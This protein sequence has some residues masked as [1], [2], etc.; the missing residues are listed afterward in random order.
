MSDS[1]KHNI[2]MGVIRELHPRPLA[3]QG[4][5]ILYNVLMDSA[6]LCQAKSKI[7]QTEKRYGQDEL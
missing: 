6:L 5:K 3:I 4:Q 2:N 7:M 1:I